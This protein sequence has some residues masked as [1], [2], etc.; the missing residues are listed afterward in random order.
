MAIKIPIVKKRTKHFKC[1]PT[2][3]NVIFK[4]GLIFLN[5]GATSPIV[6]TALRKHGGNPRVLTTE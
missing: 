1:V 4:E 6:T 2:N 3:I 5:T